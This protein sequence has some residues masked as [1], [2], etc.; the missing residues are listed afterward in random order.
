MLCAVCADAAPDASS[1]T[2]R[3]QTLVDIAIPPFAGILAT[4]TNTV[5][6]AVPT[7]SK[8]Y[9]LAI[10]VLLAGCASAPADYHAVPSHAFDRPGETS[11]GRANAAEQ[12][13]HPGLS[14]FRLL[15]GGA[16]ALMTRAALADV[17]ERSIDLK[18]FI[19]EPD[20]TGAFLLE[21]LIAAADRG[22][23]VRILLDDFELRFEDLQLARIMDAH[24]G[25]EI[26]VFNPLPGRSPWSRPLQAL[27]DA[28]RLGR[29]MHNKVYAVDGHAAILG[30]RN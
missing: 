10:A 18:Y 3:T 2:A 13:R 11:L 21:R 28:D 20:E 30:G 23:R 6:K 14:G 1:A 12:S 17:A 4:G 27:L 22:V 19:F 5:N 15:Q 24:P 25:I 9:I 16:G 8:L 29:R 26:R 7:V